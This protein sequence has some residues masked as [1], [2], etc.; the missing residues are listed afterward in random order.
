[1]YIACLDLEGVLVPEIWIAVAD[2]TGIDDLRVTTRDVGDYNEL[3]QL[4][5]EIIKKHKLKFDDIKAAIMTMEPMEGAVEFLDKLRRHYQIAILSDTFYEFAEFLMPKLGNPFLLCHHM[6]IG[7]DGE[8]INYRLRQPEAKRQAV[9]AFH[10]LGCKV[11]A[12]G[13]SYNDLGMLE[14]ADVGIFFKVRSNLRDQHAMY[15]QAEDYPKL[16]EEFKLAL[17][18]LD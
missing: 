18:V 4:R 1:M 15:R 10:Q 16:Y 12:A 2:A 7:A 8:I 17:K 9:R 11:V 14:E 5:L 6:E 3:M 13:D